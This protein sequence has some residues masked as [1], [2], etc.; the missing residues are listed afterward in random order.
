MTQQTQQET[1]IV[2]YIESDCPHHWVIDSPNGPTSTGTC[3]VCG[4]I[5]EFKNSIQITS[6]ES[7]GN[8]LN[9][10]RT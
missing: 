8:H 10:T 1:E 6:W 3:R 7:E 4:E 2:G 9:R 5:R